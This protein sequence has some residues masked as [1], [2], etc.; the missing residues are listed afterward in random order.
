MRSDRV[1]QFLIAY[2]FNFDSIAESAK[3]PQ[4]QV[5]AASKSPPA[6]M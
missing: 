5:D 2:D 6:I 4:N 3:R 1:S